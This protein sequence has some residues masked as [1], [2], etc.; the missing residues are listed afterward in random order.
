MTEAGAAEPAARAEV[1]F[2][3]HSP[4][5]R[6][7]WAQMYAGM[8]SECPVAFSP[9]YGGFWIPTRYDD[10]CHVS[11]DDDTFASDYDPKG[12]RRGYQGTN[13]PRV[14]DHRVFP[15][16][17]DPP[18]YLPYRRALLPLFNPAVAASL[19]PFVTELCTEFIDR[20]IDQGAMD[21]VTD[22]ANPVPAITLMRF[23]GL[24]IEQWKE[25]A[26]PMH[27]IVYGEPGSEI[28]ARARV[29]FAWINEQCRLAV[30]DRRQHPRDDLITALSQ[31][32]VDGGLMTPE[33]LG[34]ILLLVIGGGTDT[35]TNLFANT[36]EWLEDKPDVR[37]RLVDDEE[38]LKTA[39]EEFLRYF[40]PLQT[41]A[42][43][44]TRDVELGG[45]RLRERDRLLLSWAA[46]NRDPEAFQDPDDMV[47][48]RFP[49][50]HI[51]F[52]VG[53]HRCIG[54]HIARVEIRIMLREVLRRIRDY[55]I[56]RSRSARY[57]TVGYI[58]GFVQ[59]PATFT[60]G[61]R[62]GTTLV[63]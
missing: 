50:R 12:E 2:D 13:I 41:N 33:R 38:Y 49:N 51:A 62:I 52:G 21:F 46:A 8:R 24:P 3:H 5:Y 31:M 58:N 40:S 35:A 63:L 47:L 22:F 1:D 9:H 43:T 32:E 44:V 10:I 39:V 28:N 60:P 4:E 6:E 19:E 37:R 55:R 26:T 18:E 7:R 56:D 42:R 45:Q 61:P 15:M 34:E 57:N 59:M 16:E 20:V 36:I 48:D 29:G 54:S 23:L 11:K 25:Y 53:I 17:A 27:E 14:S 30:I